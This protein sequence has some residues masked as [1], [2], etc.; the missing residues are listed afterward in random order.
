M[1]LEKK[2][3]YSK[4]TRRIF[5]LFILCSLLPISILSAVSY[6]QVTSSLKDQ[7]NNRMQQLAKSVAVTIYERLL[8]LETNVELIISEFDA[9]HIKP[10]VMSERQ[11]GLYD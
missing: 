9:K 4:I 5:I 10:A 2:I 8:L 6:Y 3:F 7:Y 1:K 11:A